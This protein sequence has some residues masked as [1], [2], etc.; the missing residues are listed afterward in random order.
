MGK[1]TIMEVSLCAKAKISSR[2]KTDGGRHGISKH[3]TC[4]EKHNTVF[5]MARPIGRPKRRS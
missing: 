5:A 4:P 3:T 2:E 1:K